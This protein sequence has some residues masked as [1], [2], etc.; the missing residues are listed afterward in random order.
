M[1]TPAAPWPV[2]ACVDW[3]GS[4]YVET[5]TRGVA[6]GT[7]DLRIEARKGLA[8]AGKVV[9]PDGG[10]PPAPPMAN[11]RRRTAEGELRD[12]W[13]SGWVKADGSFRIGGLSPGEYEVSIRDES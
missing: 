4:D 13:R 5:V 3:T 2:R 11:A 8:I 1:R 10:L 12:P 9:G 6:A 7:L